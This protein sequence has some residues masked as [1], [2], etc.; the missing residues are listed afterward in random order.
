MPCSTCRNDLGTYNIVADQGATL[1]ETVVW[2]DSAR[3]PIDVT[4]YTARMQVRSTIDSEQIVLSL[5]TENGRISV[6]G[7]EGRFDMMV[8]ATDMTAIKA[9]KYVYDLEIIAPVTEVVDRLI[10][11]NFI[12]RGEVTR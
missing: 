2:K 8:S 1:R 11:G 5:T 9:G 3:N 7:P 4:N 12:V 6:L 10:Q